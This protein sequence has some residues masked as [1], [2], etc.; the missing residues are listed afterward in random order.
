MTAADCFFGRIGLLVKS[1]LL[2]IVSVVFSAIVAEDV[3]RYVD[4]YDMLS[5]P[6]GVPKGVANVKR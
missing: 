5:L 1:A 2:L 6:L 3:V 4:G